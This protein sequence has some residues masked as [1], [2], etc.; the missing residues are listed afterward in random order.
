M[1][2]IPLAARSGTIATAHRLVSLLCS[3]DGFRL[4]F[5]VCDLFTIYVERKGLH[6]VPFP[7]LAA[8]HAEN[9]VAI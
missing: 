5:I 8:S 1:A 9:D 7:A 6:E 2:E 3:I 4:S